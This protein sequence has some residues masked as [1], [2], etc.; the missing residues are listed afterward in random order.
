MSQ[1]TQIEFFFFFEQ[2][3]YWLLDLDF[4]GISEKNKKGVAFFMFKHWNYK[5]GFCQLAFRL[6]RFPFLCCIFHYLHV[7]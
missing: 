3:K 6:V 4:I 2:Q 5:V 1:Y 7:H